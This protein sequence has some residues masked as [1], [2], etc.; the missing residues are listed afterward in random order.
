MDMDTVYMGPDDSSGSIKYVDGPLMMVK[1]KM[2]ESEIYLF[3]DIHN[4]IGN[5]V[6]SSNMN[7]VNIVKLIDIMIKGN[8]DLEIDFFM[9]DLYT[10]NLLKNVHLKTYIQPRVDANLKLQN[11]NFSHRL[12]FYIF[13]LRDFFKACSFSKKMCKYYWPNLRFHEID[14]R[15][16]INYAD[17]E[18]IY[19]LVSQNLLFDENTKNYYE[20]NYTNYETVKNNFKIEKEIS[21]IQ[22]ED[23]RN[24]LEKYLKDMFDEKVEKFKKDKTP[25]NI[26]DIY[27]T[28]MDGYTLGRMLRNFNGYKPNSIIG[29]FGYQH[30]KVYHKFLTSLSGCS[31]KISGNINMPDIVNDISDIAIKDNFGQLRYPNQYIDVN[32]F[33]F[34]FF[35]KNL[36]AEYKNKFRDTLKNN[37]YKELINVYYTHY[38]NSN[39]D[40]IK[41]SLVFL[42][43]ATG[44]GYLI[45]RS[46]GKSRK[47]TKKTRKTSKKRKSRKR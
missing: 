41:K 14:I 3:G 22:D 27:S 13:K 37:N 42:G 29:F 46:F 35:D 10:T 36:N 11:P 19:I 6:D 2:K 40:I 34:P 38:K 47:K 9:E 31:S 28:I 4:V 21:N 8:P 32:G 7:S 30:L 45:S 17:F 43:L 20:K 16:S 18:K 24:K 5:C 23:I 12:P 15:Q 44:A 1:Y 33:N 25:K 39:S 26:L